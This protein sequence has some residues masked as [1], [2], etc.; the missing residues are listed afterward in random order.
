LIAHAFSKA[1]NCPRR[2]WIFWRRVWISASHLLLRSLRSLASRVF[3]STLRTIVSNRSKSSRMRCA[4]AATVVMRSTSLSNDAD[5]RYRTWAELQELLPEEASSEIRISGYLSAVHI[6]YGR[7][8]TLDI[9][10][11]LAYL[12]F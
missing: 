6:G 10:G 2:S 4:R 1:F 5:T 9:R 8:F 7:S 11:D 3:F 12:H